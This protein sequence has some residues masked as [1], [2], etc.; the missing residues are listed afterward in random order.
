[1]QD[2]AQRLYGMPER[3]HPAEER[4]QDST[5]IDTCSTAPWMQKYG[6]ACQQTHVSC[7]S[8]IPENGKCAEWTY[9]YTC[10]TEPAQKAMVMQCTS[11]ALGTDLSMATPQV[12]PNSPAKAA[13]LLEAAREISTYSTCD[14]ATAAADPDACLNKTM[15]NG[16]YETCKKGYWGI[17]NCC[18]TLPGG[19]SN[20]QMASLV[21]SEGASVVKFAGAKAVDAA[22]PYVFDMLYSSGSGMFSEMAT[23]AGTN[24]AASGLTFGAYGLTYGTGAVGTTL[25]G[26]MVLAKGSWGFVSFNPYVFAAMVAFTVIQQLAACDESEQLLG[27]HKGQNL[28]VQVSEECSSR[29]LGACVE[30]E[31]GWCSYNG[32]IGKILGT[33]GRRQ[34]GLG[35][36]KACEGISMKQMGQLDWSK[37]DLSELKEQVAS[38]ATKN[39]PN[40]STV[41]TTYENKLNQ[42]PVTEMNTNT[43]NGLSYP[44]NYTTP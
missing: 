42:M 14:E 19:K 11:S 33:Q 40:S 23:S 36:D 1:M 10:E 29:I 39:I 35:L 30:W 9:T 3:G 20:A 34:L 4:G 17:K 5:S 41:T 8:T 2:T 32:A 18:K 13:A 43:A 25:P 27:M 26:T 31:E 12:A 28:S 6:D 38:Q 21:F 16:V 7:T 24:F 37:L 44:S 22:S 15:F